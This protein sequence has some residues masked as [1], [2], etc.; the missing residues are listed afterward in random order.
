MEY[1]RLGRTGLK[2]SALSFGVMRLTEPAVLF[3]ALDMGINYFDTAH[4][5]QRGNNEKML[6][7]VLKEYG[8]EKVF[9]ATKIPPYSRFLNLNKLNS[10]ISM[11]TK[12]EKS[13]K[14]LQT[15]Y[16]DVL[17]LHNIKDPD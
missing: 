14:R 11:E 12:M 8:R 3:E 17:F 4:V 6:G 2:I 10:P 7:S 16:V 9:I 15:N 1:R 13:L 5:Y